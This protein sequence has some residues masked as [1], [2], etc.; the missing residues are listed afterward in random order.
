MT[1]LINE[2]TA[3]DW[4]AIAEIYRAGID[5]G[6]A[7][8][9]T[10]VPVWE[11]WNAAHLA[12]CRLAARE[13]DRL[14]AWAALSPVSKRACYRG[15]AEVSIY[16]APDCRAQGVGQA[17]LQALISASEENGI[18]TLQGSTFAENVASVRLQERCGFRIAGRRERIAQLHGV[19]RDTILTERRSLRTGLP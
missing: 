15:V 19:W 6:N 4:P 2:F 3:S 1:F 14:I 16:V 10:H 18:W 17:L 12:T 5:T 13:G 7:T 8:F 9:E 11:E